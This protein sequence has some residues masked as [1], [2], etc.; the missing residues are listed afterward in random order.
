MLLLFI[1]LLCLA[2][3]VFSS[4]NVLVCKFDPITGKCG[5]TAINKNLVKLAMRWTGLKEGSCAQYGYAIPTDEVLKIK[6]PVGT[7]CTPV[8]LKGDVRNDITSIQKSLHNVNTIV[9]NRLHTTSINRSNRLKDKERSPLVNDRLNLKGNKSRKAPKRDTQGRPM[10][11][12]G[13]KAK[14]APQR[15]QKRQYLTELKG[16]R[17][18]ILTAKWEKKFIL[19]R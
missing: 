2:Q 5:E 9:R 16:R 11:I 13:R 14:R 6:T 15:P 3:C 19:V 12:N 8:F 10:L 17:N 4:N 18:G 1:F 7:M